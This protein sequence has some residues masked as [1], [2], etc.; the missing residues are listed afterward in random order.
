MAVLPLVPLFLTLY[1]AVG[2][3]GQ[4]GRNFG[5]L[6]VAPL[7]PV[8]LLWGKFWAS[9]FPTLLI[10]EIVTLG[11]ALLMGATDAQVLL[12]LLLTVWFCAGFCAIAI[13]TSLVNPNFQAASTRR[14]VSITTTYLTLFLNGLYWLASLALF[15]WALVRLRLGP[16]SAAVAQIIA[17]VL[18]GLGR[19]LDSWWLPAM[20]LGVQLVLWPGYRRAL[21]AR[22]SLDRGLGDQRA[23]V[24]C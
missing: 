15:A 7:P 20:L 5:L 23:R 9:L 13:G 19:Y 8:R 22:H 3:M 11:L 1:Y 4:E 16:F 12:F 10:S 18:P 2:T 14:A 6:R 21:A 17:W 24:A